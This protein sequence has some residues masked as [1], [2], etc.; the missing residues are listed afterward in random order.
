MKRAPNEPAARQ[1]VG[2]V[3]RREI[4]IDA[5]PEAVWD[6]WAD[7]EQIACWF[8]DSAQGEARAGEVVT[9]RFEHFGYEFPIPILEAVRGERLVL[10]GDIPG[11]PPTLQEVVLEKEGGTTILRLANSGFGEGAEWDD[12]Y[13]GV[14]SGWHMALA[15]LAHWLARYAPRRRTHLVAMRPARFEYAALQPLFDTAEGLS[16]WLA[17]RARFDGERL[18]EGGEFALDLRDGQGTAAGRVLARTG[19]ELLLEWP[20]RNAVLGLKCFSMGPAGRF[21][22]LDLSAW[23]LDADERAAT[24]RFL[25]AALERLVARVAE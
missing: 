24:Q 3:V 7:A 10:G 6:A 11:R 2:R 21:V 9:W 18:V 14:D 22:A 23:S 8:V 17:E 25:D 15:T 20:A 19:R 13:E 12:E 16:E 4:R 5:S 1:H